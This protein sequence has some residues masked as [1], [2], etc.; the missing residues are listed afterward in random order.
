[1][2]SPFP[3]TNEHSGQKVLEYLVQLQ[4]HNALLKESWVLSQKENVLQQELIAE[5]QAQGVQQQDQITLLKEKVEALHGH[6][7]G[8]TLQAFILHQYY[9]CGVS[10]A[11]TAGMALVKAERFEENALKVQ[12]G[13][14]SLIQ[15][16]TNCKTLQPCCRRKR[17]IVGTE[18][19]RPS[20]AQQPDTGIRQ[21]S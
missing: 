11:T 18:R 5:L 13:F 20:V 8:P 12:L 2:N 1:M 9:G 4:Q 14:L 7:C 3:V 19:L 16:R 17:T 15:K 6:H 21:T 10:P